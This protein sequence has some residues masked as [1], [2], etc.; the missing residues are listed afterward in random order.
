MITKTALVQAATEIA[1]RAPS[2]RNR[3]ARFVDR[4]HPRGLIGRTLH[5]VGLTPKQIGELEQNRRYTSVMTKDAAEW[6][7]SAQTR[8]R[9]GMQWGQV[10][11]A[12][13]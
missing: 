8:A 11:A 10:V 3:S 7:R 13:R 12:T 5:S 1:E 4:R 2:A 9:K 6:L